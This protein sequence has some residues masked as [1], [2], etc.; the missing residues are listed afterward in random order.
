MNAKS[1]TF[2]YCVICRGDRFCF[3][4]LVVQGLGLS[5]FF[6]KIRSKRKP[7]GN[8]DNPLRTRK[9]LCHRDKSDCCDNGG[10]LWNAIL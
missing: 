1:M 6:Q 2:F 4:G 9:H 8:L 5:R 3:E 10:N 7:K